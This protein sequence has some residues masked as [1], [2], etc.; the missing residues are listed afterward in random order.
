MAYLHLGVV[1]GGGEVVGRGVRGLH[2]HE[3]FEVGVLEGDGTTNHVL[4]HGLALARGLEADGVWL[5]RLYPLS[6]LIGVHLAVL[7]AGVDRLPSLGPRPFA[8]FGEL[9]RRCEIVVGCVRI[10]ELPCGLAVEV[11]ALGLAVW[12]MRAAGLGA[13]VP[14]EAD[15]THRAPELLDRLLCRALQVRVLYS[16]HERAAVLAREEPVEE[17]RT[18]ATDVQPAR[19]ARRV[20]D[21]DLCVVL[22]RLKLAQV[23]RGRAGHPVWI[24]L[25]AYRNP[26]RISFL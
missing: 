19:R 12:G 17:R 13:L 11:E 24:A 8:K 1:E 6:R 25:A 21:P 3:V 5:A 9:L 15:P 23:G 16:Q 14:V 26:G 10:E 2:E 20:P 18:N 22:H 4:H 7:A